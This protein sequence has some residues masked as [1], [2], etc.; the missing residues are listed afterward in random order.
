MIVKLLT[1]HH[2]MLHIKLKG[3]TKGSNVVANILPADLPN[4]TPLDPEDGVK[5]S[6]FTFLEHG[7]VA[8][9][10]KGNTNAATW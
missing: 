5:R 10:I 3:I 8:Y 9:Q 1:E 6:K 2:L 7:H 4:P